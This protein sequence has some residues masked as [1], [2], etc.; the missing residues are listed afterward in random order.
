M[1]HGQIA[2]FAG[3]HGTRGTHSEKAFKI[4]GLAVYHLRGGCRYTPVHRGLLDIVLFLW[5]KVQVHLYSPH[6]QA[7][8]SSKC[9]HF[10]PVPIKKALNVAPTTLRVLGLV[11]P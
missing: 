8:D 1:V 7:D 3:T 6:Q 11:N 2:K 9:T 4:K 10:T 5:K